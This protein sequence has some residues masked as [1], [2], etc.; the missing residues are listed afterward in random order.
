MLLR[1]ITRFCQ[2]AG[3]Q[4]VSTGIDSMLITRLDKLRIK[5]VL[6]AYRRTNVETQCSSLLERIEKAS[7]IDSLMVP[8]NLVTMNSRICCKDLQTDEGL[9]VHL[10]YPQHVRSVSEDISILSPLGIEIF[11]STVGD[12]V[13]FQ[14]PDGSQKSILIL[15]ILYQPETEGHYLI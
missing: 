15:E 7:V 13:S 2:N 14:T 12:E 5:K 11:G 8:Q 1:S 6:K 9:I 10:V 4:W 3:Y